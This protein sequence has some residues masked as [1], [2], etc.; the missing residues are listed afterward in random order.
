MIPDSSLDGLQS[1]IK[2]N[3]LEIFK[4]V[5]SADPAAAGE[6]DLKKILM[7]NYLEI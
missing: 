4:N 7:R 6:L 5:V 2:D 1:Q 3:Y